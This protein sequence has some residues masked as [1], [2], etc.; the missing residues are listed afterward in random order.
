M[1]R[2]GESPRNAIT[3]VRTPVAEFLFIP[4]ISDMKYQSSQSNAKLYS[5]AASKEVLRKPY[6]PPSKP[7][8]RK[9]TVS[10]L[11]QSGKSYVPFIRLC[12]KW[13]NDAVFSVHDKVKVTVKDNLLILAPVK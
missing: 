4:K 1:V 8:I 2:H 9:L 3:I 7:Y 12:G 13:L 11:Y 6:C 10:Y 5:Y